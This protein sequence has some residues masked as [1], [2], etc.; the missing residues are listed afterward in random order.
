MKSLLSLSFLKA[1]KQM[2]INVLYHCTVLQLCIY[3]NVKIVQ[4]CSEVK[5][6][7]IPTSVGDS[8]AID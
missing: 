7:V 8:R 5:F 4:P 1:Q 2:Y 6:R 3:K